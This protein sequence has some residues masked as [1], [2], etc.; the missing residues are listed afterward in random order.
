VAGIGVNPG[1]YRA[2]LSDGSDAHA[3]CRKV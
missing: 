2:R 3:A 1:E